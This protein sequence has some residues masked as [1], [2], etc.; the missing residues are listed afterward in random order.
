MC[1]TVLGLKDKNKARM[2]VFSKLED[3]KLQVSEDATLVPDG[4]SD[5]DGS[6]VSYAL[7]LESVQSAMPFQVLME[8]TVFYDALSKHLV[9]Q[10]WTWRAPTPDQ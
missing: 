4:N 8:H 5:R 9:G 6:A 3:K 7:D 1:A 2:T 10:C